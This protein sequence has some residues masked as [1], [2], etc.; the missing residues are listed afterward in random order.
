MFRLLHHV[1]AGLVFASGAAL[2]RMGIVDESWP[3]LALGFA[4]CAAGMAWLAAG[5]GPGQARAER[6]EPMERP[7]PLGT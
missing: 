6:A 5:P 4:T 2:S 1:A 7:E 3:V